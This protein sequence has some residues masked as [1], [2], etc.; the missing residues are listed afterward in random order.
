MEIY[1]SKLGSFKILYLRFSICSFFNVRYGKAF[2]FFLPILWNNW[3]PLSSRSGRSVN[4]TYGMAGFNLGILHILHPAHVPLSMM[5]NFNS[6][7]HPGKLPKN[8][9]STPKEEKNA[10]RYLKD[11]PRDEG[12]GFVLDS[13]RKHNS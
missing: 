4:L 7:H 8:V 11:F 9:I 5:S 3:S 2:I 1:S 13:S 12:N 6:F 10:S